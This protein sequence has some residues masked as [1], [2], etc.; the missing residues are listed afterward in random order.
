MLS[1]DGTNICSVEAGL[2]LNDERPAKNPVALQRFT[3]PRGNCMRLLESWEIFRLES[4]K[5]NGGSFV[6]GWRRTLVRLD[7]TKCSMSAAETV[8]KYLTFFISAFLLQMNKHRLI[9]FWIL[10]I[11]FLGM[12]LEHL[13]RLVFIYQYSSVEWSCM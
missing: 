8:E 11:L 12:M 7:N 10:T 1:V 2:W 4:P 5:L 9:Y 3:S 6:P 13:N